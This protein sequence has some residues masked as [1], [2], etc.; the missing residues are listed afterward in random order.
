MEFRIE[1]DTKVP[2]EV[3]TKGIDMS[4]P[5]LAEGNST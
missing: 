5:S 3:A 1:R 2:E 4:K